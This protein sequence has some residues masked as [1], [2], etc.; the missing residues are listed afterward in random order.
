MHDGDQVVARTPY[1]V[2]EP[3]NLVIASEVA[4]MDYLRMSDLPVP[5]VYDYS[6]TSENAANTEYIIIDFVRGRNLGD[7]WYDMDESDQIA[8]VIKL[9]QLEARLFKLRFPASRSLYYA[10]DLPV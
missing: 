1:P 3:K 9:V 2:T 8:A 7:I 4:T 10:K 5:I 6:T